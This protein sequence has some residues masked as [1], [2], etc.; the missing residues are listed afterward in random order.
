VV[1]T[2]AP[3]NKEQI[4]SMAKQRDLV[5]MWIGKTTSSELRI[6]TIDGSPFVILDVESARKT[7]SSTLESQLAAEVVTA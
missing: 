5:C 7:Y 4:S 1:V 2:C 3:T 6:H